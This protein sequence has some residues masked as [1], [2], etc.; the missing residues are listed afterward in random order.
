MLAVASGEP[1]A[2]GERRSVAGASS[3]DPGRPRAVGERGVVR[4]RRRAT[5]VIVLVVRWRGRRRG[6]RGA[7][8]WQ[9]IVVVVELTYCCDRVVGQ[10]ARGRARG[11]GRC[12][13]CACAE[14]A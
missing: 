6:R 5:P 2:E 10:R 4:R 9:L 11:E 8:R 14:P 13:E 3:G 7:R 12:G 1:G